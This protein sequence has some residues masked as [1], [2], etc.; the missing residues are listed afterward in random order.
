MLRH[1]HNTPNS[2]SNARARYFASPSSNGAIQYASAAIAT[3]GER[4]YYDAISALNEHCIP[5]GAGRFQAARLLQLAGSALEAIDLLLSVK[6]EEICGTISHHTYAIWLAAEAKSDKEFPPESPYTMDRAI[7]N[8][9]YYSQRGDD[10]RAI[11]NLDAALDY[12]AE[13][14]LGNPLPSPDGTFQISAAEMTRTAIQEVGQ[15]V[16]LMTKR[17]EELHH[18]L[19]RVRLSV[20]SVV[21]EYERNLIRAIKDGKV[22]NACRAYARMA[23]AFR[24]THS[25]IPE[26]WKK[27][28]IP[29]TIADVE[30]AKEEIM[31]TLLTHPHPE[32]LSALYEA[33]ITPAVSLM[34]DEV[35]AAS[36]HL[37]VSERTG[38]PSATYRAAQSMAALGRYRTAMD[39][40]DQLNG[41]ITWGTKAVGLMTK[42]GAGAQQGQRVLRGTF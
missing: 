38:S 5:V 15:R 30:D 9:R 7:A 22:A 26:N 37:L 11:E 39:L 32:E 18:L 35:Y 17:R 4:D 40:A 14:I 28:S 29:G 1:Q 13:V 8:L 24:A 20:K 42:Q 12:A 33:L 21:T 23:H 36:I 27:H 19:S 6:E 25:L 2:L 34:G 10:V 41:V 16:I 31:Q 3:R